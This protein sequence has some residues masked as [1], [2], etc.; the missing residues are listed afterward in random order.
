MKHIFLSIFLIVFSISFAGSE[1]QQDKQMAQI[2]ALQVELDRQIAPY[3]QKYHDEM[4][5][6]TINNED[7]VYFKDLQQGFVNTLKNHISVLKD[8][9]LNEK[10]AKDYL[11]QLAERQ[12]MKI[13]VLKEAKRLKL[14][15]STQE[16]VDSLKIIKE[17][18]KDKYDDFLK[19]NNLTEESLKQS[20][21]DQL[22]VNELFKS[23]DNLVS[24][25][26]E[27]ELTD[28]YEKNKHLFKVP[29]KIRFSAIHIK[30]A[31]RSKE[32]IENNKKMV[33][34]LYQRIQ[35]G[36]S[37][38]NLA[39]NFSDDKITRK[40]G[41][42]QGY[43]FVTEIDKMYEPLLTMKVNEIKM[44]SFDEGFYIAKLT[45]DEPEKKLIFDEIKDKLRENLF[46]YKV[47]QNRAKKAKELMK[48]AK[49]E[50]SKEL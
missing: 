30:N 39:K 16:V 48:S 5:L 44:V 42:D 22:I 31:D 45:E 43:K 10:I 20:I 35:K 13:L 17:Q 2:Q 14:T 8:K 24:A 21:Q 18:N 25:L 41:G 15:V 28:S 50:F 37:F 12:I 27:K 23:Y 4:I 40:A 46:S 34:D 6:L 38:V 7:K 1:E 33:L 29:R 19:Y 32:T 3:L 26:T 47:Q 36:Q 49:I 9:P 11:R